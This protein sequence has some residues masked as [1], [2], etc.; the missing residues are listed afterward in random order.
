MA[1]I[2]TPVER[3][4][5]NLLT[6]TSLALFSAWLTFK[7]CFITLGMHVCTYMYVYTVHACVSLPDPTASSHKQVKKLT[8][9][10]D[11]DRVHIFPCCYLPVH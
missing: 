9:S 3:K 5:V 2:L 1:G 11:L 7:S 10:S 6:H 4:N 8:R